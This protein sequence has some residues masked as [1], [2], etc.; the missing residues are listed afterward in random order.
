MEY[1]GS[2][3]YDDHDFFEN[4]MARRHRKESPNKVIEYP[5]LMT[6]LGDVREKTILDL[7]CGDASLGEELLK[8]QCERYVGIDGSRNMCNQAESKLKGA[9]GSVVH[10][11]LEGYAYPSQTFDCVV[12]QLVLHYIDDLDH[13]IKKVYDTLKP[14]GEFVFS[15]LHPV[16]TASF[17]SMT[18]KRTD[19]IVDDYF[20]TGRRI[21]PWI[22]ESVVKY[23]RTIEEYFLLLQ[24]AGFT[25]K[26]LREGTPQRENF[27]DQDE[28][29]RRQRIPLFLLLSC[30]KK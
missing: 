14:G 18:G 7:G 3:V 20:Q 21:E 24:Q 1:S 12:S 29:E 19:W 22:G 2:K 4:Y 10:T 27:Q 30:T 8:Q 11:T 16:M 6:L 13:I 26:G 15:V 23:H 17:K 25:I 9:N 5:A 28:Y